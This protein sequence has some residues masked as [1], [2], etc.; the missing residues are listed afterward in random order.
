M[1]KF[2]L[3]AT[4]VDL[5]DGSKGGFGG[6]TDKP[7]IHPKLRGK[8]ML[9]VWLWTEVRWVSGLV[10]SQ[11]SLDPPAPGSLS[12]S[13]SRPT[14]YPPWIHSRSAPGWICLIY[15]GSSG[16]APGYSGSAPG[17]SGSAP[18][19]APGSALD[20]PLDPPL[21][22]PQTQTGASLD[23]HP[24]PPNIPSGP[25]Q[26]CPGSPLDLPWIHLGSPRY[27]CIHLWSPMVLHLETGST[28][29]D[30]LRL[31]HTDWLRTTRL[32]A[33][34]KNEFV[35][36]SSCTKWFTCCFVEL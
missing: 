22:V 11:W 4:Q 12:G 7:F 29:V 34:V 9:N 35:P 16:S 8:K 17:Y 36:C 6:W 19:L 20:P 33:R 25:A 3:E 26:I 30:S 32:S 15:P 24:D 27:A 14:Q 21:D 18:G 31:H 28:Q 10:G 5:G 2:H 23:P 13:S 1:S